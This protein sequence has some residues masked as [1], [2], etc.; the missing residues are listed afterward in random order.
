MASVKT[1]FGKTKIRWNHP[2][3]HGLVGCWLFNEGAGTSSYSLC[4]PFDTLIYTGTNVTNLGF[5]VKGGNNTNSNQNCLFTG[6]DFRTNSGGIN[7]AKLALPSS[8][9]QPANA[10]SVFASVVFHS[11]GSPTLSNNP[12]VIAFGYNSSGGPPYYAY[13]I[14]RV[15]ANPNDLY[16]LDDAG[17]V[18]NALHVTNAI[19]NQFDKKVSCALTFQN[20]GNIIGYVNGEQVGSSARSGSLSYSN[21]PIFINGDYN[22]ESSNIAVDVIYVWNRQLSPYEI[23]TLNNNPYKFLSPAT[24]PVRKFYKGISVASETITGVSRIT[25]VN[26]ET[27]TGKA[28][29]TAASD[30]TITGKANILIQ[31]A[32]TI[33]GKSRISAGQ[34]QTITGKSRISAISDQTIIGKSRITVVSDQTISGKANIVATTT[35]T[36]TGKSNILSRTIETISGKANIVATIRE[37]IAGKANIRNTFDR[38]ITGKAKIVYL[39]TTETISGKANIIASTNQTIPGVSRIIR[40]TTETITGVANIKTQVL[41]LSVDPVGAVVG[42]QTDITVTVTTAGDL[43]TSSA[44]IWFQEPPND[45]TELATTYVNGNVITGVIPHSLLQTLGVAQIFVTPS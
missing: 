7:Q 28:R 2:L 14:N 31:T 4:N 12:A 35:E 30:Q 41:I 32:E 23:S 18:S 1:A 11:Q 3:A 19:L 16:F 45:P 29:I 36:I 8:Q 34:N 43:F 38:T 10:V 25:T 17:G 40:Q 24:P 42:Q 37:T 26:D 27:I 6:Y 9:L 39:T 22:N 33:T 21:G 13:G 20:G 15:N 5:W 44:K